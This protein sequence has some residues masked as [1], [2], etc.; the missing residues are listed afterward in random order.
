MYAVATVATV[1]LNASTRTPPTGVRVVVETHGVSTTYKHI[2]F[3]WDDIVG[4]H[5]MH[6]ITLVIVPYVLYTT[7]V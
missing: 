3:E 5:R 2:I 6:C 1:A 7:C 4:Q